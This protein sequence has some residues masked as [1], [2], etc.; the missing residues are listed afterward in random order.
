MER[1]R[2]Y[3]ESGFVVVIALIA[4]MAMSFFLITGA[5]TTTSAVKVSGNYSKTVDIFNIAEAGLARARPRLEPALSAANGFTS[6]LTTYYGAYL[7]SSTPFNGGTYEVT[8]DDDERDG[9]SN[10]LNDTNGIIKVISTGRN[11]QGGKGIIT[12]YVQLINGTNPITYPPNPSDCSPTPP[13]GCDSAILACGAIDTLQKGTNATIDGANYPYPPYGCT[14]SGCNTTPEAGTTA[15]WDIIGSSTVNVSVSG[16]ATPAIADQSTG[17]AAGCDQWQTF[18][19]QWASVSASAPG[20]E[21]LTGSNYTGDNPCTSP[22]I[23]IINT[24]STSINIK[25]YSCGVYVVASNTSIDMS[26][27]TTMVGPVLMM[28]AFSDMTFT[29]EVGTCQL[30][31][32]IIFRSETPD[33]VKEL[34]VKGNA[35]VAFSSSGMAAGLEAVNNANGTGTGGV[36]GRL[37]TAAWE[38]SY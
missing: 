27:T 11:N 24:A 18:Y 36:P 19:N 33:A 37:I 13:G 25:G 34:S 31:G 15:N 4:L 29:G 1:K 22:K 38:E 20:V 2:R 7:I 10:P 28:G 23:F 30:L 17:S 35:L 21:V 14:G 5:A 6:I 3:R 26:G 8:V 32:K 12:T 9:D 16:G